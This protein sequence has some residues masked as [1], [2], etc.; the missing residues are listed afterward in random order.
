MVLGK[1]PSHLQKNE[2]THITQHTQ[3]STQN[4]LKTNL[5]PEIVKILEEKYKE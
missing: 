1:L 2:T 3:K 5:K 4:G